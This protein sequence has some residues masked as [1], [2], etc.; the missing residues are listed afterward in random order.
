MDGSKKIGMIMCY[1]MSQCCGI[2]YNFVFELQLAHLVWW[3]VGIV[4]SN[5]LNISF[6]IFIL[7]FTHMIQFTLTPLGPTSEIHETQSQ[8]MLKY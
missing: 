8:G 3:G 6:L 7:C 5:H 1:D 4:Y 2:E